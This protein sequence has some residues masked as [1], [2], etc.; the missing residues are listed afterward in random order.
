MTAPESDNTT[1]ERPPAVDAIMQ[2]SFDLDMKLVEK[3]Y[4][5]HPSTN[6]TPFGLGQETHWEN[7]PSI[8]TWPMAAVLIGL[9]FFVLCLV[10][11]VPWG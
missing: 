6:P 1:P 2:H 5:P 9:M 3:G 11:G 4:T 8:F 7:H 10:K